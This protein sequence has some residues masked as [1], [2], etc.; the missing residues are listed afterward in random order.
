MTKKTYSGVWYGELRTK[1]G[2][3]IVIRD[4]ELPPAAQGRIYLYN[5]ERETLVQYDPAIVADK[6]FE[7]DTEQRKQAMNQFKSGWEV[8][9]QQ[10]SKANGQ[11]TEQPQELEPPESLVK[12]KSADG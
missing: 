5:T 7:L 8:A 6:L 2:N 1:R 9:K 10:I 3:T 12:D 4:D 11:R